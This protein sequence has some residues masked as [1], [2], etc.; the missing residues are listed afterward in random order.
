MANQTNEQ[1]EAA[2]IAAGNLLPYEGLVPPYPVWAAVFACGIERLHDEYKD[3]ATDLF[4]D[5]Y[6]TCINLNDKDLY[7]YHKTTAS[8]PV[9][10][11]NYLTHTISQRNGIKAFVQWTKDKIRTGQDPAMLQFTT[12]GTGVLSAAL[13]KAA[14]YKIYTENSKTDAIQPDKFTKDM[15]WIVWAPS[16]E[17]YLR[18][19]PGRTGVP[20]SY[21]IRQK[22]TP[23]PDPVP[24][25]IY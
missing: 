24:N 8:Q 3:V 15:K 6:G 7:N 14:S 10:S 9:D 19:I 23:D 11:G 13:K 4:Q 2:A 12:K 16:F 21:V 25:E 18:A 17:N 5:D 1:R 20:L 22:E